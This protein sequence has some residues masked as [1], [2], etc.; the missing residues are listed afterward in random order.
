M[1][2]REVGRKSQALGCE[3]VP[4]RGAGSHR[5]WRYPATGRATILPDWV[6]AI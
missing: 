2:Y 5:K 6:G 3:E 4:R 1:T